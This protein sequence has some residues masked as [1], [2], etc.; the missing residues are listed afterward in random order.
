[1]SH[2]NIG[3][4][5]PPF[6]GHDVV[7]GLP[8]DLNDHLGQIVVVGFSGLTWCPPCQFEAPILQDLWAE[9]KYCQQKVQFVMI[10][11]NDPLDGQALK[12]AIQIFGLTMPFLIDPTIPVNYKVDAV[13]TLYILDAQHK[14][15]NFSIGVGPDPVALKNEISQKL[16]DCGMG[17]CRSPLTVDIWAAIRIILFIGDATGDGGGIGITPGGGPPIHIDPN[18]PPTTLGREQKDIIYSLAIN[19]LASSI[20]D[21]TS[22]IET[23]ESAL[24]LLDR[25]VKSLEQRFK[26]QN[27]PLDRLYSPVKGRK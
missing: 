20:S 14:V 6:S 19:Q 24:K 11:V 9:V 26:T 2:L 25:S 7:T 13:P 22:R 4:Q 1:M 16:K 27:I 17:E 21:R 23:Q 15:C 12:N 5:A 8:F 3:D 10:S 18:G